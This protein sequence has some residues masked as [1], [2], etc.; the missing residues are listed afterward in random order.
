[1]SSLT[2]SDDTP[3]NYTYKLISNNKNEMILRESTS[4][5]DEPRTFRVS[6]QVDGNV[7][8]VDR[9]LAQ[10]VRV[11]DDADDAPHSGSVHVVLAQPREGVT[12]ANMELEWQ[13]LK[14]FID[15][16]W[17]DFVGGFMPSLS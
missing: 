4:T 2:L 12:S 9:H 15:A 7:N 8:G 5:L 1:M 3:T 10:L 17:D 11:D 16:N 13:K 6:H 14:N